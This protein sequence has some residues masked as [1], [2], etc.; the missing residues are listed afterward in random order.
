LNDELPPS[1]WQ[2]LVEDCSLSDPPVSSCAQADLAARQAVMRGDLDAAKN[3]TDYLLDK[4]YQE[5]E[6][7]RFCQDYGLCS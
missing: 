2:A 7:V 5:P 4:R 1:D 3:Y 6:F